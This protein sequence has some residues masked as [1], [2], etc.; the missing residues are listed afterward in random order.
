V[1][2]PLPDLFP[3]FEMQPS[4]QGALASSPRTGGSGLGYPNPRYVAPDRIE[5]RGAFHVHHS[6]FPWIWS[7]FDS[8]GY[9]SDH[10][11]YSKR[12]TAQDVSGIMDAPGHTPSQVYGRER[13]AA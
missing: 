6:R 7:R 13:A 2:S 8:G 1:T 3:G 10:S 4:A 12:A 9:T 11:G 5:A